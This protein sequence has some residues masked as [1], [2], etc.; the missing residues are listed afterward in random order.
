[1][2]SNN[3]QV[4]GF[5]E[6]LNRAVVPTLG[7][8]ATVV[9]LTAENSDPLVKYPAIFVSIALTFVVTFP[10]LG[11]IYRV[12]KNR[13]FPKRL[14]KD[15][16]IRLR[17]LLKDASSFVSTSH[18]HSPFYV[19]VSCL[20]RVGASTA[21]VGQDYQRAIS[22]YLIDMRDIVGAFP[23]S[24][25]FVLRRMSFAIQS[26]SMAGE[27]IHRDLEALVLRVDVSDSHK[28]QIKADWENCAINL[29]GWLNDWA[30]FFKEANNFIDA[31]C[32]EYIPM[33][34]LIN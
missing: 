17:M 19:W 33:V 5:L 34:R 9:A 1:M 15:Q 2:A 10:M 21:G 29:N 22:S 13:F 31:D 24:Q 12:A 18:T 4:E 11:S 26:V 7:V 25:A 20:H 14:T 6:R 16:Q 8:I 3:I 32:I 28:K 27:S 23:G 30:R